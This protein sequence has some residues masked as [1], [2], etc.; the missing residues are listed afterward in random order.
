[1]IVKLS[2]VGEREMLLINNLYG[3]YDS[4]TSEGRGAN[5]AYNVTRYLEEGKQIIIKKAKEYKESKIPLQEL[6]KNAP[7]EALA[8]AYI[9]YMPI[10]EETGEPDIEYGLAYA[11]V[12]VEYFDK[13]NDGAMTVQ[14]AGPLGYIMDF[15]GSQNRITPGKVLAWLIFQDCTQ[16]FTGVIS[17]NEATSAIV[18]AQ[19]EPVYVMGQLRKIYFTYKLDRLE[20]EFTTP[21]ATY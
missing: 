7:L 14:E 8:S 4:N 18:L 15:A 5:A 21:Q 2:G 1:M 11:S 20:E 10:N 9:P 17:P 12:Y 19:K 13:D 16:D 6:S 3:P